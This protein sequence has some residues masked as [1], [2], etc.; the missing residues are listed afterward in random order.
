MPAPTRSPVGGPRHTRRAVL[1]LVHWI[2]SQVAGPRLA[3]ASIAGPHGLCAPMV[4]IFRNSL[5]R[6]ALGERGA[7]LALRASRRSEERSSND[8]KPLSPPPRSPRLLQP[9][10]RRPQDGRQARRGRR[11]TLTV[12][13]VLVPFCMPA[14][15][16]FGMPAPGDLIPEHRQLLERLVTRVLGAGGPPVMCVSP[17]RS[18]GHGARS[19]SPPTCS[20]E[21]RLV[22]NPIMAEAIL[23]ADDEVRRTRQPRGS[24]AGRRLCDRDRGRRHGCARMDRRPRFRG[25]HHRPAGV[26]GQWRRRAPQAARVAPQVVPW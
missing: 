23:V 16:P 5:P 25:R 4:P 7:A 26:R 6:P 21:E 2:L 1:R 12:L 8:S 9:G 17:S 11:G 20:G 19:R 15:V 10:H 24:T 22:R 18:A 3:R 13:H 14:D